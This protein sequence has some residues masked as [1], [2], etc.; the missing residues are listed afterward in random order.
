MPP[1]SDDQ[2]ISRR[3]LLKG[4][5]FGTAASLPWLNP[6]VAAQGVT[7]PADRPTPESFDFTRES[8]ALQPDRVVDS[9]CQF[10]NSNCR[11]KVHI[12]AGR[13]IDVRGESADPVQAGELC[14]KASMM[15]ELLYNRHR[16][17][18]PLKRVGG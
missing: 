11:L 7:P 5:V 18:R 4:V 1:P 14:V 16:L 13:V 12:K 15:V 10:C 9:A 2:D 6:A 17:R 8:A 3:G